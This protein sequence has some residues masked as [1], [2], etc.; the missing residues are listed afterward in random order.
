MTPEPE[1]PTPLPDPAALEARGCS[2]LPG[3]LDAAACR[4]LVALWD[5]PETFRSRVIM[6]R[7]RFGAGE[8]RYFDYPLPDVV[9]DLRERLYPPLAAIANAWQAQLGLEVRY[10]GEL[11]AFRARCHAAGQTRPTPLLLRYEAGGYNCL[12]QDLYGELA[13]PLQ[14]T[15]L[16]GTP[17]RDFSGG[18]FVLTEQRPRAQSR[19]HVVP[20]AEGDAVVFAVDARPVPGPRGYRRVRSRHGVS[21]VLG[22]TRWALGIIFHDA[23]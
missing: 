23:A 6:Q 14:A 15:V 22:G 3:V 1:N 10:P 5:E 4:R 11:D 8:Y 2:V 18:E 9:A 16:L 17:G 12:H 7:H 21:E 13:F 19:V 20:L